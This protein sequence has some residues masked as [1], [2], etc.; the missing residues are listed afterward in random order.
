MNDQIPDFEPPPPMFEDPKPVKKP[1]RKPTKK[2]KSVSF[3]ERKRQL[4]REKA[5]PK[6]RRVAKRRGRPPGAL[7]KPKV[8]AVASSSAKTIVSVYDRCNEILKELAPH[9]RGP[10]LECLK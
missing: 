4:S 10:V 9:E 8:E 2:A 3:L 7:G 1:R 6:K 5:V